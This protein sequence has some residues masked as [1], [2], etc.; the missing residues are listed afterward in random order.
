MAVGSPAR[1]GVSNPVSGPSDH[2]FS[3][4]GFTRNERRKF[5]VNTGVVDS[6]GRGE[7]GGEKSSSDQH[8]DQSLVVKTEMKSNRFYC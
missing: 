8:R 1:T 7:W 4:V 2:A 3:P 6:G 5:V